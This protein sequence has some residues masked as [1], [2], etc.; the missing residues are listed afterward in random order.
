[1]DAVGERARRGISEMCSI[2]EEETRDGIMVRDF[3]D[4]LAQRYQ[5]VQGKIFER[6]RGTFYSDGVHA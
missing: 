2:R 3:F 6:E 5:P 1:M 4:N